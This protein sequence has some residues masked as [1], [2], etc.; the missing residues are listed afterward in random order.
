MNLSNINLGSIFGGDQSEEG[1]FGSGSGGQERLN[2]AGNK[3]VEWEVY[4]IKDAQKNAFVL[5]VS[6]SRLND[7]ES[8]YLNDP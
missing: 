7:H 2:S 8:Y 5:P 3:D 6:V 1:L 4:V